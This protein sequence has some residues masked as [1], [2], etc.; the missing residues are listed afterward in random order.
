MFPYNNQDEHKKFVSRKCSEIWTHH[1][2]C[3]A[4]RDIS[5]FIK[6][7]SEDC[8]FI[9][10]P[11]GGHAQGTYRGPAEIQK[12]CEKFFALFGNINEFNVS[13]GAHLSHPDAENG[14]AMISWEIINNRYKVTGGVDTFVIKSGLFSIVTVVY[15]VQ[16]L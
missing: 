10:N 1:N 16:E 13:Q 15:E 8:L 12:W 9:N 3:L 2:E 6:D 7:F 5:E 14:V 4:A 11:L